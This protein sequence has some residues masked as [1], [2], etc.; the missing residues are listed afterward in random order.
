M[1]KYLPS[2][3]F[4]KFIGVIILVGILIWA[5]SFFLGKKHIFNNSKNDLALNSDDSNNPY[6]ADSD[7]DGIYDWEEGLWG[8]NPFDPNSNGTGVDDGVYIEAQ[9]R[10]IQ[11]KNNLS[12]DNFSE[13]NLNQ[14][15]IFAR[16][17]FSTASLARQ[18]GG[19]ST[20]DLDAFSKSFGQA[21]SDTRIKDPFNLIDLKLGSASALTYKTNLAIAFDPFLK[22]NISELEVIYKF[23]NGDAAAG[24]KIDQQATLYR[25]LSNQILM[26]ETPHN[27]AGIE[28]AMVNNSAK[29][30]IA[31]INMRHISDDPVLAMVGLH[32][33]Q[34]YSQ[35][36]E[37]TLADLQAYFT[38]NGI[39]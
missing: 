25:N 36:L 22:A 37:H 23:S 16:Q 1:N 6:M 5:G 8:T 17:L 35:E 7:K 31:F 30:A 9:K 4:I 28:L 26:V 13:D 29:L 33:Y 24:A 10:E 18:Q 39:I 20:S 12:G 2:K 15:E 19:L 14:T 34:Q 32:Q 3:K 38:A 21:L 27:A 11:E